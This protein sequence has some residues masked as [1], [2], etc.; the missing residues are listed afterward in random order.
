M[1]G[2]TPGAVQQRDDL[3]RSG[4]PDD[5]ARLLLAEVAEHPRFLLTAEEGNR[6]RG[7]IG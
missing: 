2:R 7:A 3:A 6:L 4:L 1:L 5:R